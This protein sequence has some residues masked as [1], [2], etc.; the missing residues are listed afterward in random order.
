[1]LLLTKLAQPQP[2]RILVC[3]LSSASTLEEASGSDLVTPA[4]TL[5]AVKPEMCVKP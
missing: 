5:L 1:M 4:E 3:R 2:T